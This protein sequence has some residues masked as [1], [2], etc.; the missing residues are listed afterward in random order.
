MKLSFVNKGQVFKLPYMTVEMQ[1]QL[2]EERV[3]LETK[4]GKDDKN[5]DYEFSRLSVLKILQLVD[6]SVCMD[7]IKKMHIGDYTKLHK[8]IWESGGELSDDDPN[9]ER[10]KIQL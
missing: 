8:L 4:Y 10:V 7:D 6:K 3:K 5:A 9:L 2:L 1:E